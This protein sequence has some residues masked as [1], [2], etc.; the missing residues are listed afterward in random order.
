MDTLMIP[1]AIIRILWLP[2]MHLPHVPP[3]ASLSV[4]PELNGL[5]DI[6]HFTVAA[7]TPTEWVGQGVFHVLVVLPAAPEDGGIGPGQ[8][9]LNALCQRRAQSEVCARHKNKKKGFDPHVA[10]LPDGVLVSWVWLAGA[11]R[12]FERHTRLRHALHP[13]LDEKPTH[14]AVWFSGQESSSE[15]EEILYTLTLNGRSLPSAQRAAWSGVKAWFLL[16]SMPSFEPSMRPIS[17]ALANTLTRALT[18]LPPNRLTPANYRE[19]V[20]QRAVEE[21]WDWEEYGVERLQALG[22]GAFLAVAQGSAEADAAIVHLTWSHPQAI[23][24]VALVGKGICFDTGGLNL[25]PARYMQGMHGD[26]NGSA[27]VLGLIQA[28]ARLQLPLV[29]DAWLAIA[30]N[31][32]GPRAYRQNEVV[33]TLEGT[34]LEVVHT[35]AEGRMVLADT[36]TLAARQKPDLIVDFATLTGSMH[37]ALGSRYSGLFTTSEVLSRLAEEAG[38]TSG[39]RVWGFPQDED[40]DEALESSVADIKQCTLEGEADHILAARFLS[41][42]T[43]QVPWVHVDLSA[44]VHPEGLGAVATEVTGFGVRWGVEFLDKW[45][46][47]P[48]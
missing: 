11:S 48:L 12:N 22:A 41:R 34:T 32:V 14:L 43:A 20:R 4:L 15:R 39:E 24:R 6:P 8:E 27:V 36:L 5:T 19:F 17:L 13:L 7:W 21:H 31:S 25:K 46:K 29:V 30:Q 10:M 26:M 40:Y 9:T 3:P 2:A 28:I 42:F 47:N 45:I 33:T 44:S 1:L 18:V 35:D 37:T 16:G 38:K 23:R